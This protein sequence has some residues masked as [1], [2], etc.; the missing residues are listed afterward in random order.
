VQTSIGMDVTEAVFYF[1][2]QLNCSENTGGQDLHNSAESRGQKRHLE[3][4]SQCLSR[5]YVQ[6]ALKRATPPTGATTD[7]MVGAAAGVT[8]LVGNSSVRAARAEAIN[9][10]GS[11]NVGVH[12]PGDVGG[13]PANE[14]VCTQRILVEDHPAV[15]AQT[16]LM[17]QIGDPDVADMVTDTS[18]SLVGSDDIDIYADIVEALNSRRE[19]RA[20]NTSKR[21]WQR[22]MRNTH[23]SPSILFK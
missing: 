21:K 22:K 12:D 6:R 9:R 15:I 7:A 14:M 3:L 13:Q 23:S 17:H 18:A 19:E 16:E 11:G 5:R 8:A 2:D 1:I 10:A 20:V 4:D